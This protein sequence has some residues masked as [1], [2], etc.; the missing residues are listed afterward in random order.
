MHS[1]FYEGKVR[2]RRFGSVAHEFQY[3]VFLVYVDLEELPKLFGRRGLWSTRF[4][5]VARFRRAD[6]LGAAEQPIAES[7]RELVASRL[8]WRPSGP[9]RLLTN[10][11]YFGFAMNP[12]SVYYCFD[13]AGER[14]EAVVAEVNNTP[15]NEKHCYV[16]DLRQQPLDRVGRVR[17]AKEFHVSPFFGMD[18]DYLWRLREPG[19]ELE[20]VIE[21]FDAAGKVFDVLL[22]LQRRPLTAWRRWSVLWRYPGMTLQVIGAIYWQAFVLWRKEAKFYPHPGGTKP[23]GAA[24]GP[25]IVDRVR[26][27]SAGEREKAEVNV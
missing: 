19:E 21:S 26:R 1:C 22:D 9:I 4:P 12:L 10:F 7:V 17:H 25:A 6:Y 2:H 13:G 16:H 27:P 20:I 15:W 5:A 23:A 11:R 8:G 3:P 18:L 14:L 24:A